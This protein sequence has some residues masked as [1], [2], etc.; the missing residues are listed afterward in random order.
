MFS[1]N[2]KVVYPGHG[3]ALIN[4]IIERKVAGTMTRFFELKFLHKDMTILVPVHNMIS[5]GIRPLSSRQNINE[6]LKLLEQPVAPLH[7]EVVA[8]WNKR[9]KEYQGKIR[10]GDLREIG[11]I[12]RDLKYI[13]HQKELS[14]GEKNLLHQTESLL[15]EEIS[16]VN[17]IHEEKAAELLRALVMVK[18]IRSTIAVKSI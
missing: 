11:E 6:V 8:N 16:I 2:E 3:V 9:N 18:P 17:N 7:Q 5:V 10:T 4:R 14:F 1:L 15:V 13:E 12:Y